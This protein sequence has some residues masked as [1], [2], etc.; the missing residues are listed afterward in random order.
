MSD[1]ALQKM[2]PHSPARIAPS[3][4]DLIQGA[5]SAGITKENVEVV[6]ELVMMHREEQARANKVLFNQNFFA[7]RKEIA[8]L[9]FYAD[10][11]A[12]TDS[13][14]V[15]YRYCSEKEI[16]E[17]LDPVLFKHGFAMMFG[18][19]QEGERSVAV[20]T[21]VHEGGHEETREYAV[22]SGGTNRMKDATAADT[23][24]TTSAWRHLC[25]KLFGLKSRIR[26]EDDVR[27]EG[28]KNEK[29]TE[30][31]AGELEHRAKMVNA[32]IPDFLKYAKVTK[33]ADIPARLYA[34]LDALLKRKEGRK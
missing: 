15:A 23:G 29:V 4:L 6:K 24:A 16:S 28:D 3:P 25:I 18:Q 22:R 11:A 21:L 2:E 10:K 33:F 8:T 32:S 30:A 14:Q 17:Q 34:E 12:K 20:I 19:R 31:Q 7:M 13:G 1:Q 9:N 26:E 27:N 5:I